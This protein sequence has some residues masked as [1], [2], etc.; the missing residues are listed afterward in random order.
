MERAVAAA[1]EHSGNVE[2]RFEGKYRIETNKNEN[3]KCNIAK[4]SFNL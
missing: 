2:E 1:V 3:E 4:P